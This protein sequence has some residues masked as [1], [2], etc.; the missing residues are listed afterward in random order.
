MQI[1]VERWPE[2]RDPVLLVAL[3]GWVDA[4]LAGAGAAAVLAEQLESA[5]RFGHVDLTD[6]VDLQQTRPTVKLV[7]GA[8]REISWPSVDLVAG[9]AARDVVLCVGPEPSL[10]WREFTEH[11][12]E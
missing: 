6:A 2:L 5:R 8:T 12:V 11:L 1:E 3:S 10:R 7:D 9:R 4:G